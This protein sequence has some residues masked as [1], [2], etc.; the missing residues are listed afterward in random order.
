MKQGKINT[1]MKTTKI[2]SVLFTLMLASIFPSVAQQITDKKKMEE[3]SKKKKEQVTI[4]IDSA[5][6][7]EHSLQKA[8]EESLAAEEKALKAKKAN[9]YMDNKEYYRQ[10][11]ALQ[12]SKR[13]LEKLGSVADNWESHTIYGNPAMVWPGGR[14][15]GGE[16]AALNVYSFVGNRENNSLNIS[17]TLE[18]VT[19]STDFYYDTKTGTSNISFFVNGTLKGGELKI[20]LKKPDKTAFQ[21]INISP[22]ADVNWNQSFNWEEDENDAYLGKWIISIAATKASGTYRVQVNSR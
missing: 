5:R 4:I 3:E 8:M 7:S 16:N 1:N 20:T 13:K 22:L 15:D 11:E 2:A 6:H 21:E 18:E 19:L 10:A 9:G 12:D 17:K 14:L